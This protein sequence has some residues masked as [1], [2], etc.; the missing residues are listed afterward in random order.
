MAPAGR[1]FGTES[2]SVSVTR[3]YDRVEDPS[4][5]VVIVHPFYGPSA[6]LVSG[7][8]SRVAGVVSMAAY[9]G[10]WAVALVI[11]KRELDARFPRGRHAATGADP[12]MVLLRERFARGELD[13]QQFR[14]MADVLDPDRTR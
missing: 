13:E 2:P 1:A 10:F 8:G 12:A 3:S 9:L 5:G 11:A 4:E 14:S 6:R 7:S